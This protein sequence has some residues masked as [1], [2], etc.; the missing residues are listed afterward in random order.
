ML[1]GFGNDLFSDWIFI[2]WCN[3][4]SNVNFFLSIELHQHDSMTITEV[5]DKIDGGDDNDDDDEFLE[6]I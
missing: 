1:L 2:S 3:D 6:F 5:S 4:A